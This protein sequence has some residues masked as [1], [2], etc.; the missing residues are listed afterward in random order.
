ML[1]IPQ[2]LRKRKLHSDQEKKRTT[3]IA[4]EFLDLIRN[5]NMVSQSGGSKRAL[6]MLKSGIRK[7]SV[8]A[9]VR[10]QNNVATAY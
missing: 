9:K 10:K 1:N 7:K 5:S 6:Q 3:V 4:K 2:A 8:V